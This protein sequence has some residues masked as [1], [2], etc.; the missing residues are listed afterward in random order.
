VEIRKEE[1]I[2]QS[3][4]LGN[5]AIVKQCLIYPVEKKFMQLPKLA[6]QCSLKNIIPNNNSNWSE[7]DNKILD[8]FTADKN[9]C[10]FHN[11]SDD[12]YTISLN[13]DG[14][15]VGNMLVQ[16]NLA[17]FATTSIEAISGKN[18]FKI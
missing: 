17:A 7:M 11:F 2:V 8:C 13:R 4:D 14:Q 18:Y 9:E 16:Q 6:I 1:Y 10:I 3:I 5:H 12:Q 15:D